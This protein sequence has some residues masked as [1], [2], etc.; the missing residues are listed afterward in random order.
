MAKLVGA[1][2]GERATNWAQL[3]EQYR[4]YAF[5][6]HEFALGDTAKNHNDIGPI[7]VRQAL[8]MQ[9]RNVKMGV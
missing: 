4:G 7:Y 6:L 5:A 3:T 8:A 2:H 9:K 1:A